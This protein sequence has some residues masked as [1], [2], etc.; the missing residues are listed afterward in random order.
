MSDLQQIQQAIV[1]LEAQ[2][3]VLGDAVVDAS[4]SALRKQLAEL[5]AAQTTEQRK[6]VTI[7]FADLVGFTSM[8]DKLDPE[9]VRAIQRAYFA[10][11]TA[12]IREQGGVIEKYIGDAVMAVF[13][14]PKAEESDPDRAVLAALEMHTALAQLN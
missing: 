6:L 8:A 9:D 4:L 12:P 10:A 5:E 14:L 2:R 11:V 3:A 7:L 1:A 13:G